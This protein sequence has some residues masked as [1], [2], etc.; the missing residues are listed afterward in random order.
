MSEKRVIARN[1]LANALVKF[2]QLASSFVFMPFLI[3]GFGLANYGLFMLAGSLS[4]YLGL[5]DLG[6]N[7]TVVKRAAEYR[8]RGDDEGLGTLISN[9][10]A[11]YLLIGVIVATVLA[12]FARFGIGI[13]HL[14]QDN[15]DLAQ[16]L[17]TVAAVV[18]L[19][20]W[21]LGLGDAVLSGLQR[22]DLSSAV[23]SG[24]VV[25]NLAVTAFVVIT[26]DGPVVLLA[27]LGLVTIAAGCA[28]SFLA[29]RQ[30]HGVRVSPA[31]VSW[32]GVKAILSFGWRLF[33]IQG[34]VMLTDQQTDRIVLASFVGPTAVGLYEAPAK[35]S[36]FVNQMAALPVSALVPASSQMEAQERPEAL[37]ALFV[38]G[39]KYT[40]AFVA[41]IAV[42]LIAL[43][44]PLLLTWL[45]PLL[46]SQ[47]LA[48]QL[49]LV[50]WLLYLNLSVAFSVFVGTGRLRFLLRYTVIQA[51]LN[52]VLSLLLVGRWHI[53]GVI[54]GTVI[55]ETIMFPFG[56]AY[57]L[58]QL[59]V[60]PGEYLR[61]VIA[62]TY[63]FLLL[64]V[65][66][67][68][69]WVRLGVAN[70]LV[71][72]AIAGLTAVA[73]CWVAIFSFG[74]E[75]RERDDVRRLATL[76]LGYVKRS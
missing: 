29:W 32:G 19:F 51:L 22:Y 28:S 72:V 31:F 18:A 44:R 41:P 66:V 52:L 49:L 11:Y 71:G 33:V 69:G 62:P 30:L 4:V 10:A 63:P 59:E 5:L 43:A 36:S 74:L 54:V 76:V 12:L 39:T 38:R 9:S 13:F 15:A 45:G 1:T 55:A 46:A 2:L 61:R 75:Q 65:I 47:T 68:L 14:T 73:A 20:S 16:N 56:M 27:G 17:F 7:P 60:G 70:T 35:L 6:V 40:L 64:T 26:G 24:V 34:A 3:R 53:L 25:A 42:G 50:Q 67:A 58:R 8:A 48:A 57:V 23:A 37:R 21:P